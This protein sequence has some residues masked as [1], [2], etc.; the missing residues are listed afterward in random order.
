MATAA[1]T[2][3]SCEN[4]ID[5][6]Y[7]DIPQ[8]QVIEALLT[9]DGISVRL[10]KTVA[11]DQPFSADL[12]TDAVVTVTDLTDDMSYLLTAGADGIFTAPSIAEITG[13][14]YELNVSIGEETF[15]ATSTALS[16]TEI[17]SSEFN[18]IKMPYDDVAIL[19]VTFTET[20]DKLD[21][22]WMRVFR[23]GE[24]Y[25]W[26]V[27]DSRN[28]A[29]GLVT[30]LM[31]TSRR[32]TDEED[33]NI[34]LRDGDVIEIEVMPV[35]QTM[36]DYLNSLNNGDYN[37]YRLFSGDYCLGYFLAAPMSKAQIIYHPD[38]IDYNE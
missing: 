38:E 20:D 10:T 11:T 31:M 37:G 13:H 12:T 27:M 8:Q 28:A 4:E 35:S 23:N 24:M 21:R 33:D 7:H 22:Y 25:Q 1:L 19:K 36:A 18:W 34:V 9:Q 17:V 14:R 32:D 30:G 16:P 5:F 6:D 2:I 29:D 15:T 3:S 26:Q